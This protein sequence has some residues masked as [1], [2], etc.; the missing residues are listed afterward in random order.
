MSDAYGKPVEQL[1]YENRIVYLSG[2]ITEGEA[3]AVASQILV[4]DSVDHEAEIK[5][6]MSSYGGSVFAGLAVYDAMQLVEAPVATFCV[7]AAFSMAA[8][9]LAAGERGRRVTM[10]NARIMLH[11][12]SAG[13]QGSSADIRIAAENILQSERLL[14]EILRLHTGRPAEEIA[15]ALDRDCWMTAEEARAFGLIDAV[16][17]PSKAKMFPAAAPAVLRAPSPTAAPRSP[18]PAQVTGGAQPPGA[19]TIPGTPAAAPGGS[20]R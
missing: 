3:K 12:P 4:L 20:S 6:Y 5:L 8:V 15:R 1:F 13:I 14:T 7:G 16:V 17:P 10:P 19:A 9:L 11:R 2:D 18:R